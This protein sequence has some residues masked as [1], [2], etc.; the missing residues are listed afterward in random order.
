MT[1]IDFYQEVIHRHAISYPTFV[2]LVQEFFY[3]APEN[4]GPC[5]KNPDSLSKIVCSLQDR[6]RIKILTTDR[7]TNT[8]L[9]FDPQL[10]TTAP[11]YSATLLRG[12][13]TVFKE[14]VFQF[15]KAKKL[16]HGVRVQIT[17]VFAVYQDGDHVYF[18]DLTEIQP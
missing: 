18:G 14:S 3:E 12:I 2:N 8:D 4:V 16:L 15:Y 17:I 13:C 7:D 11:F 9:Q 6:D 1:S 5:I 10:T